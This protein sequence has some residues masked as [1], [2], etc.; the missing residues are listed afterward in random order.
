MG[1]DGVLGEIDHVLA[2]ANFGSPLASFSVVEIGFFDGDKFEVGVFFGVAFN[3][4]RGVVR[5]FAVGN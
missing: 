2:F 4:F 5:R 1:R 3:D